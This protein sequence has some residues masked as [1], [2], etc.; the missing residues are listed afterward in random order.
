MW[1]VRSK[2]SGAGTLITVVTVGAGN[3]AGGGPGNKQTGHIAIPARGFDRVKRTAGRGKL[4][5]GVSLLVLS[6][7]LRRPTGAAICMA[8]E[9][10]FVLIGNAGHH[11]AGR[12]NAANIPP[13]S[14][15]LCAAA[16]R[17]DRGAMWIMTI[18]A[19]DVAHGRIHNVL[20]GS[21]GFSIQSNRVCADFLE[22]RSYIF[23]SGFSPAVARKAI[24]F[25][26]GESH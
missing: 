19:G 18:R 26:F 2:P 21:M 15:K 13:I 25:R 10:Q 23:Y 11:R 20:V 6:G 17:G 14:G 22:V 1:P 12:V 24:L 16:W 4:E 5:P 8:T 3:S 7:D 9:T